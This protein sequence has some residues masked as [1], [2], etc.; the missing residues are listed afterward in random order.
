[1]NTIRGIF[2]VIFIIL[3][4][5]LHFTYGVDIVEAIVWSAGAALMCAFV[6]I[7]IMAWVEELKLEIKEKKKDG[8]KETIGK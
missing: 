5:G 2:I 3:T 1:M 4:I 8:K 7:A 6:Y